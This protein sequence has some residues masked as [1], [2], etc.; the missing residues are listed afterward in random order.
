MRKLEEMAEIRWERMNRMGKE[1]PRKK[2][3]EASG[4]CGQLT[5]P[6]KLRKVH[7]TEG[8]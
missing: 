8:K 5:D 3:R 4:N 6:R 7:Q 1:K 2:I